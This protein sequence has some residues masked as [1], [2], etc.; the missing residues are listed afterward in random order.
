M[1]K[2]LRSLSLLLALV[3]LS[4]TGC[5][6]TGATSSF[7]VEVAPTPGVSLAIASV[8]VEPGQ[9]RLQNVGSYAWGQYGEDD[10]AMLRESLNESAAL[11]GGPGASAHRVHL[12]IR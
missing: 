9:T 1:Q 8:E 12:I 11:L 6:L 2:A 7:V 10:L 3:A 4:T 5:A